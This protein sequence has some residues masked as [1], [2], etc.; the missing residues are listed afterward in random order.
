MLHHKNRQIEY[1]RLWGLNQARK[2]L[3][4]ATSL[5]D[6]KRLLMAIASGEVN[7]VDRLLSIGIEQKRGARG[8]MTLY[9]QAAKNYYNPKSFTEEEEDMKAILM[10]RL[11]GNW[12]AEI[13][14]RANNS[15]NTTYL[16]TC[17]TIPPII[18]SHSKPMVE[19]VQKNVKVTFNGLFEVIH[20]QNPGSKYVHAVLMFDKLATEKR[21]LWDPKTNYFL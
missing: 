6:Q 17:T 9:N 10:W 5:N 18:P 20:S 15:P 1:Y 7:C 19:E 11:G 12:L 14:H 2:L 21:V 8:L 16:R 3:V 4:K 13:N